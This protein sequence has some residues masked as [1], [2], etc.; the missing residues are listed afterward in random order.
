MSQQHRAIALTKAGEIG[1]V[2]VPTAAP[3]Q[4]QVQIKVDSAILGP[5]DTYPIDYNFFVGQYPSILGLGGAG[6]IAE[7]GQGVSGFAVGD[8]VRHQNY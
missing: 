5:F 2:H 8:R 7:V 1:V 4:G 3:G 6:T